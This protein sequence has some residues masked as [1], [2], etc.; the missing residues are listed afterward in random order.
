MTRTLTL[1]AF[2]SITLVARPQCSE[3]NQNKVLLVG[4]S[5]A[6]FMGVDQTINDVFERWGHSNYRYY[7]NLT[8]AENGAETDDFLEADKQAEIQA[9]LDADPNISVVHLSIGGNDVLGDWHVDFTQAQTDSLKSA[10]YD[11]LDQV[12]QF[13]KDARPGI[14]IL[15]SG[16]NYPNFQEV[17]EDLP[18]FLQSTH[19]FYSTWSGM[20]FPTFEQLNTILNEFSDEMELYAL[21]DPQVDFVNATGLMQYTYGQDSPLGV[22]PGGSYPAGTVDLPLGLVDYPSPKGSMRNYGI[23]LD[24]FHLSAGGYR[25]LI[26]YHTQKFYHKFLM[27]DQYLLSQGGNQDGTVGAQGT[28][29]NELQLGTNAGEAIATVLTFDTSV[30]PDTGITGASIFLRRTALTGDNPVGGTLQVKVASGQFGAT[31]EV[32]ADDYADPGG[33]TDAAC[34]FGSIGN[35]RWIRLDLPSSVISFINDQGTTQFMISAPGAAEGVVTFSDASDPDFAPVLNLKFGALSVDMPEVATP[36]PVRLYPNPTDGILYLEAG[37]ATLLEVQ[38]FDLLGRPVLQGGQRTPV[39]DLSALPGG[40]YVVHLRTD[41]GTVV[42]RVM[43][44]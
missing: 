41:N 2:L 6:F 1:I 18:S 21:N 44:R 5:W 9:R 23:F 31:V 39:L 17:I 35:N 27:D 16:Y 24:C 25:D 14:R 4:D 38:V 36:Q 34:R 3:T 26:G 37:D 15:W 40:I 28:V 13:I 10:V 43:R 42:Q 33:T 19:P 8:L 20:G 29:S 7:T 22:A 12:I 30:L 11:R 32:E